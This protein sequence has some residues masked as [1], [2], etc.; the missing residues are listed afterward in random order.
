[1]SSG[2]KTVPVL[3]GAD[4]PDAG[5]FTVTYPAGSFIGDFSFA[6]GH[7]LSLNGKKLRQP[8]DIGLSF[9]AGAVTVTNRTGATIPAGSSGIMQLEIAGDDSGLYGRKTNSEAK[10]RLLRATKLQPVAISLGAPITAAANGISVSQSVT[11]ATTPLATITGASA[12]GG[13]AT[14]DVPRAVV[15]AW[16]G[17]SVLTVTGKD[18]YGQTV[19]EASASGTSLTGKKAFKTVTSCSFSADVTSATVGT[20]DVL[21]LPIFKGSA[22]TGYVIS[23]LQDDAVATAGTFVVGLTKDTESTSTSADVRGTYDPN[24]ACDGA[25]SFTLLM[26]VEDPEDLGNPQY[27]G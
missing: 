25:K 15:A 14:L 2:F 19:I 26:V 17:T 12:S 6:R 8:A 18:E 22:T 13:I 5:T 24:A 27:A 7:Y 21:G 10:T 4:V 23:E 3:I 16:T 11:V 20:G 9:A 1:M